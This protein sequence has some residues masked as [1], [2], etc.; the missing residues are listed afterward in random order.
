MYQRLAKIGTICV[1]ESLLLGEL[2]TLSIHSRCDYIL[3]T[4][5]G[6]LAST[7]QTLRE[8]GAIGSRAM[9]A[10]RLAWAVAFNVEGDREHNTAGT[11]LRG[12][13]A[14]QDR[15]TA[16]TKWDSIWTTLI[17]PLAAS[18]PSATT[19]LNELALSV[20]CEQRGDWQ[21]PA[22]RPVDLDDANR[23]FEYVYARDKL[24]VLGYIINNFGRRLDHSE[25]I[26]NEA[27][28]R[29][30][31]DYWGEKARRRF[32][33]L[34]RISTLVCQVARYVAIDAMRE[35]G[36]LVSDDGTGASGLEGSTASLDA[37]GIVPD[38]SAKL[39]AEELQRRIREGIKELPA[40]QRIVAEMVWFR[41]IR[42]QRVAELLQIS[43]PAVSQHLKKARDTLRNFLTGQGFKE[44]A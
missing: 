39:I 16:D 3:K 17:K 27:W 11:K 36:S 10:T 44:S 14:Y 21:S 43:E 30:F 31:C 8:D 9:D 5:S 7:L 2:V 34:C 13:R 1:P 40:K 12:I 38:P 29:V 42:A 24:K 28:S 20:A 35:S 15:W 26:A 6:E 23:V 37:L 25:A 4:G 18:N 22:A 32:L 33:G 41:E 19:L